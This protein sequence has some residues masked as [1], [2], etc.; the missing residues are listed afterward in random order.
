MKYRKT[1]FTLSICA[2]LLFV[3]ASLPAVSDRLVESLE[4]QYEDRSVLSVPPADAI[5]VLGGSLRHSTGQPPVTHITDSSD[6]LLIGLRLYRAGKAPTVL[7]AGGNLSLFRKNTDPPEA[8]LM[9]Q[10]LQ[11]WGLP[12]SAIL[13]EQDSVN[14]HQNATMSF[15]MLS[16]RNMRRVILVTSAR[17]M[18][19]A[20]ATFRKA[21]F[22]V[23]PAPAD[24]LVGSTTPE[25]N[26]LPNSQS[27]S[28]TDLAIQ[29]WIGLW[30]YRLR[31]W[32]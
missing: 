16:A 9:S 8:Q 14:T 15:K 4:Q 22:E 17:H 27:L 2:F 6:R 28:E 24:F 31:G 12:T 25:M 5:V 18:P 19:R 1:A 26:W 10:L 7:C 20:V 21:G 13:T 3:A 23:I 29:E 30:V 32:A 11:E